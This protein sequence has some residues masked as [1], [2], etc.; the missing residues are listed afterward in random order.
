M[1]EHLR[2]SLIDPRYQQ[3]R[4]AMLSKI[5]ETTKASDDEIARNLVGLAKSR[6]DVFGARMLTWLTSRS[7]SF[8]FWLC[9][10]SCRNPFGLA[11]GRDCIVSFW[12]TMPAGM[13]LC[14][15]R[16]LCCSATL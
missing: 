9:D 7:G 6:P 13:S 16:A 2:V 3:Q 1:S 4:N 10:D 12:D 5:R 15:L 8:L 14:N 11:C